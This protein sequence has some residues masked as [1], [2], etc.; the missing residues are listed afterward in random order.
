MLDLTLERDRIALAAIA[1]AL[2]TVFIPLSLA[3][4]ITLQTV[5]R[6]GISEAKASNGG[7]DRRSKGRNDSVR[8]DSLVQGNRS[9]AAISK[10]IR[11]T[12]R[13]DDDL[14]A[15]AKNVKIIANNGSVILKGNVNS[16]EEKA[17]V[18]KIARDLSRTSLV[19]NN[20]EVRTQ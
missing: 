3:Q 18:E 8:E 14:S 17:K 5:S 4:P 10:T 15:E 16:P 7:S 6:A 11:D 12:L 20:L 9:D 13:R 1:C 2:F 19:E